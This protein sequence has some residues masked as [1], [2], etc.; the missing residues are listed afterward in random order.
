M[1]KTST[2]PGGGADALARTRASRELDEERNTKLLAVEEDPVLVLAVVAEP[3]AVVGEEDDDRL[4]V[5]PFRFQETEE[6][7]DDRV[8]GRDLPVVGPRRVPAPEGLRR[9][10]RR[11]RLVEMEEREQRL[12]R[13]L[14]GD[15]LLEDAPP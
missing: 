6:A 8:G 11:V 15:P 10:V 14:S 13:R 9:I 3:L 5:D 12:F 4:V 1:G 2:R 7:S